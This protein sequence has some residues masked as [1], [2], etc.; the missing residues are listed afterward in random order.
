MLTY[1]S[2]TELNKRTISTVKA[3]AK[4]KLMVKNNFP[5]WICG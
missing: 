4:A 5:L 3:Y 1:Q 2:T